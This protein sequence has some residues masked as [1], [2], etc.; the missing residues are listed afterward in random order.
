MEEIAIEESN[1]GIHEVVFLNKRM[2]QDVIIVSNTSSLR[3]KN[4]KTETG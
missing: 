4:L 3:K 2:V 1:G